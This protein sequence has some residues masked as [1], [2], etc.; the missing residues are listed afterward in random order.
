MLL[1]ALVVAAICLALIQGGSL[2]HLGTLPLRGTWAIVLS[3]AMQAAIYI[4]GSSYPEFVRQSG[5]TVYLGAMA[6]V[7]F[8]V[9]CNWRLGPTAWLILLGVGFNLTVIA[10]NGGRMPV[11]AR[12]LSATQGAAQV[13]AVSAN[14]ALYY[15][16]VLA[17]TSTRLTVFSDQIEVPSPIGHGYVASIGD[18]LLAAGAGILAYKGTRGPWRRGSRPVAL[19]PR[20][21]LPSSATHRQQS[22][23]EL[24]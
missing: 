6:L 10:A 20:L 19:S 17:T 12:A 11:D 18:V 24:S 3:F 8:G 4:A 16:R 9:L 7:T 13:T 2:R 1:I 22:G 14:T 23:V 15:N 21:G 5:P